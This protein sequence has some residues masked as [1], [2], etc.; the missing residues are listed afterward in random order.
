MAK[1]AMSSPGGDDRWVAAVEARSAEFVE[2]FGKVC[3]ISDKALSGIFEV[4]CFLTIVGDYERQGLV[5]EARNLV[6]DGFRYLTTPNG[7]PANFSHLKLVGEGASWEIRQQ[8]RVCSHWHDDVNFTPDIVVVDEDAEIRTE[9]DQDYAAGKRRFFRVNA[10]SVVAAHECKSMTGF[11]EL[12]VS[13]VGMFLM[14]HA[15]YGD[16]VSKSVARQSRGHLAPSLFVG[17]EAS[18]LHRRMMTALESQ[19][20]I[21][22]LS[23]LYRGAWALERKAG[24]VNRIPFRAKIGGTAP[25]CGDDHVEPERDRATAIAGLDIGSGGEQPAHLGTA[26]FRDRRP[27]LRC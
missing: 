4:G 18:N 24:Q 3:S 27:A 25:Q 16:P 13:F 20:P 23:G 14:G 19:F 5:V 26:L 7:N 10:S 21:N 2:R 22:L 11:P 1:K 6:E 15:W 9:K 17:S 12:Y 8:V